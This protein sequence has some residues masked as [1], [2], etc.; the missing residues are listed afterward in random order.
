MKT[1]AHA[2]ESLIYII[3]LA[4]LGTSM[5]TVLFF[6]LVQRT[7]ALFGSAVTYLIPIIAV[8]WGIFD[9]EP[10]GLIGIVGLLLILTGVYLAGER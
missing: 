6:R 9:G 5:A 1:D 4:V 10:F 3:I 8:M 7:N 2:V